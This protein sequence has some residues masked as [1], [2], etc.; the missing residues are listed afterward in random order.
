ML[1]KL[2]LCDIIITT[3]SLLSIWSRSIMAWR[4]HGKDN[5]DLV[6]NMKSEFA[7][8]SLRF[9]VATITSKINVTP[10][11]VRLSEKL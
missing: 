9:H 4:S 7:S 1:A 2:R 8:I 6:R 11:G 10:K 3:G 5:T